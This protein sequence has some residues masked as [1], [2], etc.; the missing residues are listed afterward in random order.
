MELID[1]EKIRNIIK[2]EI[3]CVEKRF[4]TA[5][6]SK[7]ELCNKTFVSWDTFGAWRLGFTVA[8][9]II[10][11]TSGISKLLKVLIP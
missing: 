1:Y 3:N 2:E 4:E 6:N 9:V 11:G 10:G 8:L 7:A 5:M